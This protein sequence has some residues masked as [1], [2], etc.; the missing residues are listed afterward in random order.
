MPNLKNQEILSKLKEKFAK[1]NSVLLSDFK[2]VNTSDLTNFREDVKNKGGEVVVSKNTL[3]KLALQENNVD[4]KINES[5]TGQ[6]VAVL[7]YND[8]ISVIKAFFDFSKDK[9]NLKA[10]A[11]IFENKYV[12]DKE[13]KEISNL[14]SKEQLIGRL[15]G[16]FKSPLFG[17]VNVLNQTQSKVVYVFKAIADKKQ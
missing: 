2:G 6:T 4:E 7:S 10:K 17:L 5:L 16:S 11:G 14:P 9:E 8:P 13:L 15:V 12:T 3:L 1:S